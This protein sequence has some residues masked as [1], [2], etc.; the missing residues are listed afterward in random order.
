MLLKH[1]ADVEPSVALKS[2]VTAPAVKHRSLEARLERAAADAA[3]HLQQL[4]DTGP[5][6][7][8]AALLPPHALQPPGGQGDMS[9]SL[10]A[11][12]RTQQ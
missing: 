5:L 12:L 11:P 9:Y 7:D 1:A 10:V 6:R 3:A 4:A 2:N 8:T